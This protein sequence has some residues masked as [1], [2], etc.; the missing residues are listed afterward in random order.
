MTDYCRVIKCKSD[1]FEVRKGE[2]IITCYARSGNRK[3]NIVV[4]DYVTLDEFN[5]ISSTKSRTNLLIRPMVAN[6]D[7]IVIVIAPMPEPDYFLVDKLILNCHEQGID[8]YLCINKTDIAD[9]TFYDRLLFEYSRDVCE[10]LRVCAKENKCDE[11]NEI[12][13]GKLV[14][15]AGQSGVGKSSIINSIIGFDKQTIGNVSY[16]TERGK[17]TTT[18]NELFVAGGG[19]LI[20]TPG[21]TML[22]VHEIPA[23]EIKLYYSEYGD[24]ADNCKFTSCSHTVEPE[25]AVRRAA[26]HG[27]I[28]LKRL[29]RYKLIYG[30]V[31]MAKPYRRKTY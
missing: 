25:C 21:F 19:Y 26:E 14:A 29:E 6:V 11:L 13:C 27:K 7:A 4:G 20:D 16:K 31:K 8:V 10:I 18:A 2:D 15:L 24:Y 23:E 5:V 28:S 9:N 3:N 22:D 1:K 17:N 12:L 30:E